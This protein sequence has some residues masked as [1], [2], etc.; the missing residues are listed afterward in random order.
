VVEALIGCLGFG[1]DPTRV[2]KVS[3]RPTKL[4][5]STK[6]AV[7]SGD[8][9]SRV[10][11]SRINGFGTAKDMMGKKTDVSYCIYS[12]QDRHA[13]LELSGETSD[14]WTTTIRPII[15]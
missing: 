1:K 3:K 12:V 2:G 4:V 5:N 14:P 15:L 13:P 10:W 11:C 9:R 7:S 8:I 6:T